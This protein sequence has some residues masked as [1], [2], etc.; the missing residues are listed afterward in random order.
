MKPPQW[1]RSALVLKAA[2]ALNCCISGSDSDCTG[3][4]PW[5]EIFAECN[6]YC[7]GGA[8][9]YFGVCIKAL[10][11]LN[12]GG[13]IVD[14][15][16]DKVVCQIGTCEPYV[17]VVEEIPCGKNLDPCPIDTQCVPLENN[18]HDRDLCNEDIGL[19]FEPPGPAGSEDKCNIAIG[20]N[21]MIF[22]GCSTDS[23]P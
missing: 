14:I 9:D 18:C 15:V 6:A 10:D 8:S 19:C 1:K 22:G 20:N 13:N 21:C 7:A 3:F 4:S 11:C 2:A 16:D 23:C 12:N 17:G 5:N